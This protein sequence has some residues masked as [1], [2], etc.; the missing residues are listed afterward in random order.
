MKV[1]DLK[2]ALEKFDPEAQVCIET[3]SDCA[4]YMAKQY[5]LENG[6]KYV[7]IADSMEYVEEVFRSPIQECIVGYEEV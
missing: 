3:Y 5:T 4:A 6:E 1:K 2:Q 7:Y